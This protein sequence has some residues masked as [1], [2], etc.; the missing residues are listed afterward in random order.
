M[1]TPISVEVV[2]ALADAQALVAVT[3]L[4]GAVVG[5]AIEQSGIAARFPEIDLGDLP[6]G[7]WGHVVDR[8]TRLNDGD[9]VEIYRQLD[10]DPREARRQ[11]ALLGRTMSQP[12]D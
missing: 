2:F 1:S 8:D 7:V 10:I 9:R 3:L 4:D 12:H 5:D 11:L 6:V